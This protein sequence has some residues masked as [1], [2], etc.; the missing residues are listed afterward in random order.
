MKLSI[1]IPVHNEEKTLKK[2]IDY[3]NLNNIKNK[4]LIVVCNGCTD[5][6]EKIAKKLTQKTYSTP[7]A[8]VSR[9]RN[10]GA[11]KA[12]G[13]ILVFHDADTACSKNYLKAIRKA[14]QKGYDFGCAR[15]IPETNN[16][17]Y[18]ILLKVA[19]YNSE[20]KKIFHGNCFMT[21]KIFEPYNSNLTSFE[22]TELALRL[23]NKGNYIYLKNCWIRPSERGFRKNGYF[24]GIMKIII[25]GALILMRK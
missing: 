15:Q 18:K 20:K 5:G 1:I 21:K 17:W 2:T 23:K 19:N 6:S 12:T 22:D 11:K 14:V 7:I 24:L 16:I 13:D 10:Y 9:A 25:K 8:S 3:L 4:E